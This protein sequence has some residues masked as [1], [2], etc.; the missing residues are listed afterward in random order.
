MEDQFALLRAWHEWTSREIAVFKS[1]FRG[2]SAT[3][4]GAANCRGF[5][6]GEDMPGQG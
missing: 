3:V 1:K 6:L 5:T 4:L 2:A